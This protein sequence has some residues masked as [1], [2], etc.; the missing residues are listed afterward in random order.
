MADTFTER[1]S[2][3]RVKIKG[4]AIFFRFVDEVKVINRFIGP[5]PLEDLTWSSLRF[6]TDKSIHP[7]EILD[8]EITI[9]GESKVR[10]RGCVI[11]MSDV[12]ISGKYYA[13]IQFLAYGTTKPYNSIK[14]KDRLKQIIDKY[15]RIIH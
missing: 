15:S 3:L 12:P 7:G 10:V 11:W 13:V 14:I 4:A 9:P 6:A 8:V 5:E 2:M 1:R